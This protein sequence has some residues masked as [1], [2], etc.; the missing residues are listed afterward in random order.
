MLLKEEPVTFNLF[1]E[2]MYYGTYTLD[3]AMVT[4]MSLGVSI[5]A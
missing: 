4:L 3:A 5:N 2:W 1:V